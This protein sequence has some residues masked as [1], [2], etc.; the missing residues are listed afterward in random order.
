MAN[1]ARQVNKLTGALEGQAAKA[2]R[3]CVH[4]VKEHLK[5]CL[6]GLILVR[7]G[8]FF[9]NIRIT[10]KTGRMLAYHA[11]SANIW[12]CLSSCSVIIQWRCNEE[13]R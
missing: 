4:Y 5:D 7:L 11:I 6:C 9:V 8:S 12:S 3:D 1:Q 2:G 13:N 10:N